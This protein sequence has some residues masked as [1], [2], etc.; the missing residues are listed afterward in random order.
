[1][2]KKINCT[3]FS[4]KSL[5]LF[6]TLIKRARDIKNKKKITIMFLNYFKLFKIMFLKNFKIIKQN[7]NRIYTKN[8]IDPVFFIKINYYIYLSSIY[9]I[10]KLLLVLNKNY[11]YVIDKKKSN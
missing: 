8:E 7:T 1:M 11:I 6:Y 3:K 5:F 9:V 2:K 4:K 10:Y